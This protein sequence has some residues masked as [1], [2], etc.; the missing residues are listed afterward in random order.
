MD[1]ADVY[2]IELQNDD[3]SVSDSLTIGKGTDALTLSLNETTQNA[4]TALCVDTWAD[5]KLVLQ[6]PKLPL[7]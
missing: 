6:F 2:T 3:G 1:A 7:L 4:S 5:I